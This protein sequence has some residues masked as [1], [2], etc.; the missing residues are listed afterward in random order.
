LQAPGQL[1]PQWDHEVV[2]GD[3]LIGLTW[4]LKLHADEKIK[5][6]ST[7]MMP[8]AG[9]IAWTKTKF[10][11]INKKGKCDLLRYLGDK[12]RIRVLNMQQQ[13]E[14]ESYHHREK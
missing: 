5:R 6:R 7:A 14:T 8:S 3:D 4:I 9:E 1:L 13:G 2:E 11:T 12:N 10:E